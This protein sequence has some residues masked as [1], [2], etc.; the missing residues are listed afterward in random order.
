MAHL[1]AR[2][3]EL[4]RDVKKIDS[5]THAS[6]D[7]LTISAFLLAAAANWKGNRR[8]SVAALING[9]FVLGYSM[10]TDY[11]GSVRRRIRFRTHGKLDAVQATM[12]LSMPTLLGF[13]DTGAS[14][15]FRGQ[16]INEA[17]VLALTDWERT[18]AVS[19]RARRVA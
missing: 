9:F 6:L 3:N 17:L 10:F 16:A 15:F 14:A 12:A 1:F 2:F 13:S 4:T 11:P 19:G 5:A 7:Y 18:G 8:A